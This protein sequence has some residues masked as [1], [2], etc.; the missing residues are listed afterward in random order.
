MIWAPNL[1]MKRLLLL[2]IALAM[3]PLLHAKPLDL[4]ADAP[5][6]T[7]TTETGATLNLGEVYK[8]NDYTLVYF[9]PRAK[10]S[11][12]TAQGCSLRDAYEVLTKKGVA[13]IGVSTDSAAKQA[14]FKA[15]QHFPFTLIADPEKKVIDAFGVGTLWLPGLGTIAHRQAYLVHQGKIVYADHDGSTT[16]QAQDILD[17]LAKHQK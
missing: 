9:Y 15:E 6:I 8:Q 4:G 14:E 13:V 7:A 5:A 17:W 10:T 1:R 16:K 12:C 11:G 3:I 2:P